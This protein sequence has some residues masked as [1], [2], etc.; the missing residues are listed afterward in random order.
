MAGS[1]PPE[2]TTL[3]ENKGVQVELCNRHGH[4]EQ[5]MPDRALQ[6]E[7]LHDCITNL[8]SPGVMVL[9]TGDRAGY[10]R[11]K[12]FQVNLESVHSM[13]WSVEVLL[14]LNSCNASWVVSN[15]SFCALDKFY[16]AITVLEPGP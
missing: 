5:Q 1:I 10:S 6:M 7:I 2:L 15:G 16:W 14:W 11:G 3:W 12:G 13:G 8:D 4:G 9:L